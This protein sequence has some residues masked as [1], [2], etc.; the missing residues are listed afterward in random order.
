ME[1][2]EESRALLEWWLAVKIIAFSL[3]PP[4]FFCSP[5]SHLF[6]LWVIEVDYCAAVDTED[7]W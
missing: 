3:P 7:K 1:N 6:S 5:K 2:S 4:F